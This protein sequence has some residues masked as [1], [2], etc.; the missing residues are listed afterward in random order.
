LDAAREK[1]AADAARSFKVHPATGS[2]LL[3]RAPIQGQMRQIMLTDLRHLILKMT[4][5]TVIFTAV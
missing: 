1:T 3:A 4:R 5:K 2:R